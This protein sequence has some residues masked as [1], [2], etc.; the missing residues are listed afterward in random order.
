M[1]IFQII[2]L[3]YQSFNISDHFLEENPCVLNITL[4][5]KKEKQ[6][7]IKGIITAL[8]ALLPTTGCLKTN[9][10]TG[11]GFALGKLK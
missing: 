10:N 5:R 8:H 9:I 6:E 1:N 4:E 7:F 3:V 11:M 2:F